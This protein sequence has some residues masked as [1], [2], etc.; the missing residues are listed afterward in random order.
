MIRSVKYCYKNKKVATF[1]CDDNGT[2]KLLVGVVEQYNDSEILI[3]HISPHGYY[4]GLI[5]RHIEDVRR[6]DY[7]GE[8]EKK[9]KKLYQL[10]K[11][12]HKQMQ[13]FNA[14][15]EILYSLLDFAK[16][17]DCIV[18][19]EFAD[20]SI[21]GFVNGYS[22]D[23]IYLEVIN[24]YGVENGISIINVDEILYVVVDSDHEQDLK[25]LVEEQKTGDGLR[26]P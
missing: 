22:N 13:S 16:Q 21:S 19:L 1:Y 25:L 10:R 4:D 2:Q 18:S 8:Y 20:N 12:Q 3:A 14:D 6:I 23:V 11:Q 15:D 7:D 26:E 5:L 24:E 17:N 9:I